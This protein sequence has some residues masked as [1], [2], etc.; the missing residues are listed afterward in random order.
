M[1]GRGFFTDW[2]SMVTCCLSARLSKINRRLDFNKESKSA[3]A[4]RRIDMR[5][6]LYPIEKIVN[7]FNT[8][9]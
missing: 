5:S 7:K 2:R 3:A 9:E 4:K 8:I 6:M 1:D